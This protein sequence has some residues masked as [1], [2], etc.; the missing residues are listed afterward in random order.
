MK[1]DQYRDEVKTLLIKVD[2]RQEEMYYRISRIEKHLEKMNGSIARHEASLIKIKTVGMLA[3]LII[4]LT[5]N[6]I[7]RFI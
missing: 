5:I 3:V 7:M 1:V 6:V 4:P 2:T